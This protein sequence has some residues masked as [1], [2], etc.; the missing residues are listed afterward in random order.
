M[1]RAVATSLFVLLLAPSAPAQA[2]VAGGPPAG[3][4]ATPVEIAAQASLD[5]RSL[6]TGYMAQLAAAGTPPSQ[7]DIEEAARLYFTNGAAATSVPTTGPRAEYFTNGAAVT[8]MP[9]S[10]PGA[11][12][13]HD[14]AAVMAYSPA[15]ALPRASQATGEANA[16]HV[17]ATPSQENA[18]VPS[19]G[20]NTEE[21]AA[22]A[23]PAASTPVAAPP[24]APST[25]TGLTCS[26]LEIQAAMA[27]ASQF[28]IAS[29]SPS[30]VPSDPPAAVPSTG[31]LPIP[32]GMDSSSERTELA[33]RCAPAPSLLSRV[34]AA[35]M[36][37]VFFGGFGVALWLRA[38]PRRVLRGS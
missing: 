3:T 19:V 17:G 15:P 2:Q 7:A 22:P 25:A 18:G 12:Y 36:G 34:A 27:I 31:P 30:A 26:P 37:G 32:L 1:R 23:G 5:T 21:S 20:S 9:S 10:G 14:G 33:P 4:V 16:V 13:F 35:G 28:A 38:R 29:V 11:A 6:L 8:A 24:T